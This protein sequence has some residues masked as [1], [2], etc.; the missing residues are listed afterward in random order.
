MGCRAAMCGLEPRPEMSS[1]IGASSISAKMERWPGERFEEL[2]A[3][4]LDSI[5][6]GPAGCIE[7]VTVV[8]LA[9]RGPTSRPSRDLARSV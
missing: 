9:D 3:Q 1:A 2:V 8:V 5:P 6:D 4:A 7:S